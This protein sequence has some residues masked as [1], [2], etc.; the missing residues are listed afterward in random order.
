MAFLLNAKPGNG[1]LGVIQ[2][3]NY[4]FADYHCSLQEGLGLALKNDQLKTA[5]ERQKLVLLL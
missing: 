5:K 2:V 1:E 4:S 3:K